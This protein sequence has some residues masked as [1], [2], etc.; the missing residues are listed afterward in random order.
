MTVE[1]SEWSSGQL[2][3]VVIFIGE[4]SVV[5]RFTVLTLVRTVNAQPDDDRCCYLV[6]HEP[7]DGQP[8]PLGYHASSK[9]RLDRCRGSGM[10]M[11]PLQTPSW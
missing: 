9:E 11:D 1:V 3:V 6:E 2:R 10:A 8:R 5:D 7:S 4:D